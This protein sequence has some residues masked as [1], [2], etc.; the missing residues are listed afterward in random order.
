[1]VQADEKRWRGHCRNISAALAP[2]PSEL[3]DPKEHDVSPGTTGTT[4][5]L[6]ASDGHKFAAYENKPADATAAVVVIQE[7]FGVNAHIRSVVD[8][9]AAFGFHAIAPA[10]FD[11]TERK[12]E[13]EYT[14][15]GVDEG[16]AVR[17]KV[18]WEAATA[19]V[20]SAAA[21]V[22]STGPVGVVGYCWGGSIAWLAANELPIAAAVGYYGGQ[23]YQFR[24]RQPKVPTML[25]FGAIDKGIPLDQVMAV[26]ASQRAARV[27]IYG[28]A[29]HGFNCDARS[30]YNELAAKLAQSRTLKFFA[31]HGVR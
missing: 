26:R 20:A 8:R 2:V 14:A 18:P 13:L 6:T 19:D 4:V 28:R 27:H 31:D 30:S 24:D 16:K 22:S 9:Y 23:V 25:H 15:E 29:D 7:I 5:E 17:A 1:M 10:L 12:V 21:R 11:R 3:D